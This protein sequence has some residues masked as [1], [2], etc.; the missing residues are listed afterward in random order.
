MSRVFKAVIG[1]GNVGREYEHT[2]HNAGFLFVDALQRVFGAPPFSAMRNLRCQ[3]AVVPR[4]PSLRTARSE[5]VTLL[6]AKPLTM[7]N[8]SG[9]AIAFLTRYYKLGPAD[10]LVVCDD[11]DLDFGRL[12]FRKSGSSGGQNG[13]RDIERAVGSR[14]YHR[15]RVGIGR[16]VDS[17]VPLASHVLGSFTDAELLAIG[18]R[19]VSACAESFVR[20][21]LRDD[22]DPA[23]RVLSQLCIGGD[24]RL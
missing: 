22:F 1:L 7:M 15:L 13:L 16:P 23:N 19:E 4:D 9:D 17:R 6:L 2:R 3:M 14:E 18:S 10:W 21:W 24:R 12:R 8:L 5:E 11:A 20:A